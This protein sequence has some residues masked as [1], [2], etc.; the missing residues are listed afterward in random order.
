MFCHFT[1]NVGRYHTWKLNNILWYDYFNLYTAIPYQYQINLRALS[2]LQNNFMHECV[3]MANLLINCVRVS[4][5]VGKKPLCA[6]FLLK[7]ND[8]IRLKLM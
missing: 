1:T 6:K 7:N 8:L 2:L 5:V 3:R 4:S